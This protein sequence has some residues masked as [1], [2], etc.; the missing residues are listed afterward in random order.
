MKTARK[1]ICL[2]LLAKAAMVPET[3]CRPEIGLCAIGQGLQLAAGA[4]EKAP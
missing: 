1:K 3:D 2:R 4:K